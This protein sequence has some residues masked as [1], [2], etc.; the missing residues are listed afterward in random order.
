MTRKVYSSTH[1]CVWRIDSPAKV[2]EYYRCKEGWLYAVARHRLGNDADAAEAVQDLLVWALGA[3]AKGMSLNATYL[4]ARFEGRGGILE[5]AKRKR[6]R[7][8]GHLPEGVLANRADYTALPED[9][10]L[11]ATQ[12]EAF[13][14]SQPGIEMMLLVYDLGA[15]KAA[16]TLGITPNA[17]H[18]RMFQFRR[19]FEA[20]R[21][22]RDAV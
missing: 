17:L 4:A 7:V 13:I 12:E 18:Q 14:R 3:V 15:T 11:E 22:D 10:M 6:I 9:Q 21:G 1:T 8:A 2:A 5:R 19:R 20:A 16:E